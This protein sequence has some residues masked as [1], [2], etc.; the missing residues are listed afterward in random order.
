VVLLLPVITLDVHPQPAL[1]GEVVTVTGSVSGGEGSGAWAF[2]VPEFVERIG[3]HG[4]VLE[5]VCLA[6]GT[7]SVTATYTDDSGVAEVSNTISCLG[8]PST[9]ASSSTSAPTMTSVPTDESRGPTTSA[10]PRPTTSASGPA[11]TSAP[12]STSRSVPAPTSTSAP[13]SA[14]TSPP[15]T[16]TPD[17][18]L[19]DRVDKAERQLEPGMV[20]YRRPRSIREG[21]SKDFVVRVQR[22][23]T[24]ADPSDVPGEG[25]V[26]VSPIEV[27]TPMSAKLVGD[28]FE[29]QPPGA[30]HRV[31]GSN[32]PAEWSWTITPRSWG[33]K[34][35]RLELAVLLD[36]NSEN[37]IK[38][39][40]YVQ[41]IHV[42]VHP[43]KTSLRLLKG[44]LGVL[45]A[46]GLTVA[47]LA[48]A[49]WS[50]WRRS[51]RRGSTAGGT[52]SSDK[53][54]AGKVRRPPAHRAEGRRRRRR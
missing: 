17:D 25:P 39:R 36:E 7:G 54:T 28:D 8:A 34:E 22:A 42:S 40:S 33:D 47:A 29:I 30:V 3:G 46:T 14:S 21:E 23:S 43:W 31:L 12:G 9:T 45:S 10:E 44:A 19:L 4:N 38:V 48:G 49:V 35:L 15:A 27:G 37:A 16:T 13:T 5:I 1:L 6:Q 53:G 11:S 2:T 24:P 52:G 32:R 50:F 18:P 41:V 51:R 20:S 26:V